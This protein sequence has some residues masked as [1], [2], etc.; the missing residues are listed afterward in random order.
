[1]ASVAD[2]CSMPSVYIPF[3]RVKPLK[4]VATMT[5]EY[6]PSDC[7]SD[8][9]KSAAKPATGERFDVA[10]I[11]GEGF[12]LDTDEYDNG[13]GWI[14]SPCPYFEHCK[15]CGKR[16]RHTDSIIVAIDGACR[17][18][19]YA[20]ARSSYGVYFSEYSSHNFSSV[21]EGSAQSSQRAE[22]TA[23]M[24]AL[25]RIHFFS[26]AVEAGFLEGL[27]NLSQVI[28]K[29]DSEYV[30]R[31]MTEWVPKWRL[32]GFKNAKGRPVVNADLFREIDGQVQK[33]ATRGVSCSFWHVPRGNNRQADQLANQALDEAASLESGATSPY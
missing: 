16:P 29:A 20:G 21:I 2:E 1:M 18:N 23:C 11:Y 8:Q 22:L 4:T 19:G 25:N 28:V 3:P 31:G 33:L 27:D 9:D 17:G 15:Y 26:L 12:T 7:D 5:I 13:T 30:V 10:E 24:A 32:N 14:L 6:H